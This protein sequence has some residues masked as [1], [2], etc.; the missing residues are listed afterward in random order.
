LAEVW[1]AD[2]AY[3]L[4]KGYSD[5]KIFDYRL[6]FFPEAFLPFPIFGKFYLKKARQK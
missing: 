1:G 5:G 3:D 2:A 6:F 4:S